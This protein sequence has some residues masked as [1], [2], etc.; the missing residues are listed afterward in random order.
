MVDRSGSIRRLHRSDACHRRETSRAE[1]VYFSSGT[2]EGRPI[3]RVMH[4]MA[5]AFGIRSEVNLGEPVAEAKSYFLRDVFLD[6]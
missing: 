2:Q 3:D 6:A 5:E 1:A 4:K